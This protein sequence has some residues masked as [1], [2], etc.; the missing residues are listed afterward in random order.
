MCYKQDLLY[1]MLFY[2]TEMRDG[3]YWVF[4]WGK[5]FDHWF[6]GQHP[7]PVYVQVLRGKCD[8]PPFEVDISIITHRLVWKFGIYF[9]DS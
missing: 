2:S 6:I 7:V 4:A 1:H 8:I 9:S 3:Y 5:S